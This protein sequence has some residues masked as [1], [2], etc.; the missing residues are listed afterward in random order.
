MRDRDDYAREAAEAKIAAEVASGERCKHGRT[1]VCPTCHQQLLDELRE[2]RRV[3]AIFLE[4][5]TASLADHTPQEIVRLWL[6]KRDAIS[7]LG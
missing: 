1:P 4:W 2:L 7:K 5:E 6:A 3:L